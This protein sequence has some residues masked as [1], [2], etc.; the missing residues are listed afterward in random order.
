MAQVVIVNDRKRKRYQQRR[1][2]SVF[3]DEEYRMLYRFSREN[4]KWLAN[5]FLGESIETRGGKF[6]SVK[7][8]EMTLRYFANPGFHTGIASEMGVHST[9]VCK[10]IWE[11]VEKIVAKGSEWI[12]FPQTWEEVSRAKNDWRNTKGFPCTIGAIDCTHIRIQ[13]PTT[14]F[15]NEYVNRKGFH[16]INVQATV[17]EKGI[18]NVSSLIYHNFIAMYLFVNRDFH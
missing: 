1:D 15:S 4:V 3:R 9:S 11:T 10:V 13:R 18:V 16:S 8:M 5:H 17:N 2:L 7:K 14:A 12:K 6:T